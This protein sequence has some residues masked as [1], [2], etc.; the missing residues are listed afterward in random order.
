M[1][2]AW[3]QTVGQREE[4]E[5]QNTEAALLA[6]FGLVRNEIEDFKESDHGNQ[7]EFVA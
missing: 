4:Y 5:A 6:I 7:H 2:A 1:D 3:Y